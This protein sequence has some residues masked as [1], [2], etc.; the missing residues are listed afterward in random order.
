MRLIISKV[1]AWYSN[2]VVAAEC[3]NAWMEI[4][5]QNCGT[6]LLGFCLRARQARQIQSMS[7]AQLWSLFDSYAAQKSDR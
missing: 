7:Y 1:L 3:V 4:Q 6:G 5:F 2:I